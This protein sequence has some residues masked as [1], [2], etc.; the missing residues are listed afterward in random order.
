[1]S[2]S[3][4]VYKNRSLTEGELALIG[5]VD[6]DTGQPMLREGDTLYEQFAAKEI[7]IGN[8]FGV[9]W[10]RRELELNAPSMSECIREVVLPN[11][12]LSG[13]AIGEPHISR[14]ASEC[15]ALLIDGRVK[16]HEGVRRVL[17]DL[18]DLA[19]IAL[20]ENNPIVLM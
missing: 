18:G 19:K 8:L 17:A 9:A 1:M 5:S 20:Y 11:G 16:L 7:F 10:L 12:T 14:I 13:V 2:L 4:L 6:T 15:A 3:A